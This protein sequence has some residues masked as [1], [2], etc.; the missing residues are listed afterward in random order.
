[1][2]GFGGGGIGAHDPKFG[3]GGYKGG[4]LCKVGGFWILRSGKV[5]VGAEDDG[6]GRG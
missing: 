2:F 6:G 3:P 4:P 5:L 1:M